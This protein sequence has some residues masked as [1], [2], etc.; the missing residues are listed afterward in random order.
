MSALL[1]KTLG[2]SWVQGVPLL[3]Q[4]QLLLRLYLIDIVAARSSR[5]SHPL[6]VNVE[7]E[8]MLPHEGASNDHLARV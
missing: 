1:V 2:V 3:S 5:N 4:D 7:N 6:T 8:V